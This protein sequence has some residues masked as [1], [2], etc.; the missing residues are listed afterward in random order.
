MNNI[1]KNPKEKNIVVILT[2]T[3]LCIISGTRYN[4]GGSD[5][6]VYE[7]IFYNVPYLF[8]GDSFAFQDNS[9]FLNFELGY[10]LLN[11]LVKTIGFSFYG[12]TLLHSVIFYTCIYVGL[13]KYTDNFN[14]LIIVFLY[15]LFFYNTFISLR[16]SITVAIFFVIMHFIQEKKPI[17]YFIGCVTAILFHNAAIVLVPVYFLNKINLTKKKLIVLNAIFIPTIMVSISGIPVLNFMMTLTQYIPGGGFQEKVSLLAEVADLTGMSIFHTME[18]FLLMVLVVI[19][20]EKIKGIDKYAEFILKLFVC[21]LPIFTLLR[22]YEILTREKDYFTF[23]FGIVLG[24]LCL[25]N[26]K[27]YLGTV[28]ISTLIVCAYGFFRFILLFDNGGMMPYESY[29][30]KTISIFD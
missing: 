15:K 13:K 28:Q 2:L 17:K 4:L 8:E 21:L 26:N 22:G 29:L 20:F 9:A 30:F 12:F 10:L 7:T 27:K 16:Q 19:N 24:Y 5:Y 25:I 18:Y 3:V 6:G 11:S 1:L 14:L 23:T